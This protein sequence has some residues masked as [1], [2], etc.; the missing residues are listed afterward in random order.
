[1]AV[2][3]DAQNV[4]QANVRNSRSTRIA[5]CKRCAGKA[6]KFIQF[7]AAYSRL[8]ARCNECMSVVVQ[9]TFNIQK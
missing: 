7:L 5:L 4:K 2:Q 6:A 3:R 9:L 1:M 8:F